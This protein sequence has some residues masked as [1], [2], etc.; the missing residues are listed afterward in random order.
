MNRSRQLPGGDLI[1]Q[2]LQDCIAGRITP[3][4]C[5]IAM[6]WP[7][8]NRAGMNL[9]DRK[10]HRIPDPEHQLYQLLCMEEGDA[11]SRYNSLIRLLV[12]F[13]HALEHEQANANGL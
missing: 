1:A 5:L 9:Q 11:Y 2:G 8:L 7:R 10:L 6:G 13:E 12:S 3:A 4:A